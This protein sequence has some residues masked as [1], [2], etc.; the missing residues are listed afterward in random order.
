MSL[1]PRQHVESKGEQPVAGQDRGRL[2]ELL[3]RGGPA[4]AEIVVVHRRQVV[5]HQ[6]VAVH[7]LDGGA[8]HQR[9]LALDAE[10]RGRLDRQKGPQPF[11]AAEA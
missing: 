9:M 11:A 1:G 8:G 2:V 4:A 6:R 3:V 5:M 10:Q 7:E